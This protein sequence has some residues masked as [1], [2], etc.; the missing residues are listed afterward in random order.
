MWV[1]MAGCLGSNGE[2]SFPFIENIMTKIVYVH[3]LFIYGRP[4]FKCIPQ[5]WLNLHG[6]DGAVD[7]SHMCCFKHGQEG[8]SAITVRKIVFLSRYQYVI[9]TLPRSLWHIT[10]CGLELHFSVNSR[11]SPL[12]TSLG[13]DFGIWP[14]GGHFGTRPVVSCHI[15]LLHQ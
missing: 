10:C 7:M 13:T 4:I 8:D 9:H 14:P 6:L 5:N 1:L 3:K 15:P 11:W 2:E 12:R